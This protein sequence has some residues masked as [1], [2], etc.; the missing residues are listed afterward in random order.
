M[1][2]LNNVIFPGW[3]DRPKIESLA[4][5]SIAS[6]APYKNIDN[7][8]VNTPNKIVDSLLLGLPILSPLKGEVAALI[9]RNKVGFTYGVNMSLSECI[10]LLLDNNKLQIKMAENAKNLYDEEFEFDKV[11]DSLVSHLES[12]AT[13]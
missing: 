8:I 3:I 9:K 7:F 13:K 5:M 4:K 12:I 11:Y 10:Q 1:L 6:L 2:G